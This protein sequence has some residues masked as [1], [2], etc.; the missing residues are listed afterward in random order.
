MLLIVLV[1]ML[2]T[3]ARI[4]RCWKNGT[5]SRPERNHVNNQ[6]VFSIDRSNDSLNGSILDYN[7]ALSCSI[8]INKDSD[9]QF[10]EEILPSYE[11]ALKIKP[12][13]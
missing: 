7:Q 6:V 4:I 9:S 11:H 10:K 2:V 13:E 3:L 8:K 5:N 1:I 12:L